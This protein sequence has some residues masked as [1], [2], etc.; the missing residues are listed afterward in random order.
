MLHSMMPP[1]NQRKV[2]LKAQKG[3]LVLQSY[4]MVELFLYVVMFSV[5]FDDEKCLRL[6]LKEFVRS[7]YRQ[8]LLRPV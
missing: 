4:V 2:F 1:G 6:S 7:F 5:F 3:D 8:T